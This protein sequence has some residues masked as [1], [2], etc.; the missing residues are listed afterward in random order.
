MEKENVCK[1]HEN[2]VLFLVTSVTLP[3]SKY[4]LSD[5]DIPFQPKKKKKKKFYVTLANQLLK[6][7]LFAFFCFF[8]YSCTSPGSVGHTWLCLA[9]HWMCKNPKDA[10]LGDLIRNFTLVS[11]TFLLCGYRD[12]CEACY[13]LGGDMQLFPNLKSYKSEWHFFHVST[14]YSYTHQHYQVGG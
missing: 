2:Q 1:N 13:Q 7:I 8:S 10:V 14:S 12:F 6:Y 9:Q 3:W 11:I 5:L 4:S